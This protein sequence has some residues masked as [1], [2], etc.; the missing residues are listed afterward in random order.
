MAYHESDLLENLFFFT[1][2]SRCY[3]PLSHFLS[4]LSL[5]SCFSLL[6]PRGFA[7][8]SFPVSLLL[9]QTQ[10]FS[11][12]SCVIPH[13]LVIS[14]FLF[15]ALFLFFAVLPPPELSLKCLEHFYSFQWHSIV[16]GGLVKMAE[17]TLYWWEEKIAPL[18]ILFFTCYFYFSKSLI[19]LC[20]CAWS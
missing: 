7:S 17:L 4:A 20:E 3:E 18:F 16:S 9:F 5:S 14:R 8:L 19:S 10:V 13:L 6:L 1:T 11:F 12:T 15:L 2:S